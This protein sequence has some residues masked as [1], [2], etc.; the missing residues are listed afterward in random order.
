MLHLE[1]E[2]ESCQVPSRPGT[3][4]RAHATSPGP[5]S[6]SPSRAAS[7]RPLRPDTQFIRAGDSAYYPADGEHA[8]ENTGPRRAVIFLVA[9]Y[10][11]ERLPS[12]V[13]GG[14][15]VY[16]SPLGPP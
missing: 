6:C 7:P 3:H 4:W 9:V 15:R 10:R 5:A 14:R 16:T 13:A 11:D 12:C 8:I 2:A 1:K